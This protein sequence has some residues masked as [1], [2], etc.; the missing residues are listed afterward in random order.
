MKEEIPDF[1][2]T[3]SREWEITPE[4]FNEFLNSNFDERAA[5]KFFGNYPWPIFWTLCTTGGHFNYMFKEFPLGNRHVCDFVIVNCFSGL[6]EIKFIELEPIGEK[7]F[8]NKGVFAKRL[9]GA[10]AQV[11]DWKGYFETN[12]ASVIDDL[13]LWMMKK[14]ILKYHEGQENPSNY[15]GN[16]FRDPQTYVRSDYHV[17]IGKSGTISQKDN[18]RKARMSDNL[19]VEIATYDRILR[20]VHSRYPLRKHYVK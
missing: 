6:W 9:N 17:F 1:I 18:S 7:L 11:S 15:S 13:C 16:H 4:I 8:T 12:K 14:D 5:L 2:D 20:V 10:I 19:S 3:K